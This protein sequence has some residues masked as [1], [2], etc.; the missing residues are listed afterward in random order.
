[1]SDLLPASRFKRGSFLVFN[2]A[3]GTT[4]KEREGFRKES[5]LCSMKRVIGNTSAVSKQLL[6]DTV[7]ARTC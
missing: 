4:P 2:R 7:G 6:S 5:A 1:M 3:G